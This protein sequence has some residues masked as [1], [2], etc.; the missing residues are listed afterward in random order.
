[1]SHSALAEEEQVNQEETQ[2]QQDTIEVIKVSGQR[3]NI[4]SAQNMKLAADTVVDA[5][6]AE[7]IGALPDRSV[8]E[9]ISRLPGVAIERFAAADDPDHFGV[10]GGGVVVRGLTHVRSE[11]NNRPNLPES[12]SQI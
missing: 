7:D 9:A 2:E 11:F 6:S 1:M 12:N 3:G 4:I 8:L 10:E 5:I